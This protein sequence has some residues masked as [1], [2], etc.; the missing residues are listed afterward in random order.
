MG[1][2][3]TPGK[4]CALCAARPF[5]K[6][7]LCAPPPRANALWHAAPCKRRAL[8]S[9]N[10]GIYRADFRLSRFP[11]I[12]LQFLPCGK[13][14]PEGFFPQARNAAN[15]G[16]RRFFIKYLANLFILCRIVLAAV[17]A[18]IASLSP[19]FRGCYLLGGFSNTADGALARHCL[20]QTKQAARLDSG[21]DF[22]FFYRQFAY[23][24]SCRLAAGACCVHFCIAAVQS[25]HC[26]A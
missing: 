12:L 17:M 7:A 8:P 11:L 21:A 6:T 20:T 25:F 4:S 9:Q 2:A 10:I 15:S 26:P 16:F 18:F 14:T 19:A 3:R 24:S 22:L 13:Q 1:R 5:A 23:F